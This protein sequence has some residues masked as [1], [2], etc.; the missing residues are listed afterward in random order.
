MAD[1]TPVTLPSLAVGDVWGTLTNN[2]IRTIEGRI[3]VLRQQVLDL[4]APSGVS[5]G[6]VAALIDDPAS[7]TH[8]SVVAAGL[9]LATSGGTQGAGTTASRNTHVHAA[10]TVTVTPSGTLSSTTVQ[11]A[12]LEI[13]AQLEV[14]EALVAAGAGV[15]PAGFVVVRRYVSGAWQARGTLPVGTVVWWVGPGGVALPTDY[16]SG[17][18]AIY[19]TP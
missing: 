13:L 10:S 11:A 15:V 8:A 1:D 7:G 19:S 3:N 4:P 12:L 2:N 16:L 18:D 6:A 5:D 17:T 9:Q 14:L